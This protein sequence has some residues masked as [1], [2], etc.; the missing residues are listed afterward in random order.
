MEST[1]K[2]FA[3]TWKDV[4]YCYDVHKGT[5]TQML[6][7]DEDSFDLLEEHQTACT[8]MFSSRYLATFEDEVNL[9]QKQLAAISEV[10]MLC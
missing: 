7:M 10:T 1:L 4:E 8:A 6:R 5:G 2:L 9:W 3:D